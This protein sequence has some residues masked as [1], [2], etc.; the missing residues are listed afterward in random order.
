MAEAALDPPVPQEP[1]STSDA[2][3]PTR[4]P[5][6][7]SILLAIDDSEVGLAATERIPSSCRKGDDT[8]VSCLLQASEQATA[9]AAGQLCREGR[10]W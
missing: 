10:S 8:G 1:F 2:D 7:R 6:G 5:T 9:W 4:A 3:K